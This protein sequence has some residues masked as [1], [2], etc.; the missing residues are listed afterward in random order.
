MTALAWRTARSHAASLAGAF[1]ALALGVALLSALSLTLAS[2]AGPAVGPRWFTT[3]D[4]VVAGTDS[5]TATS[6]TGDNRQTSTLATG[7]AG[8]VSAGLARRLS[9]L[10]AATVVDYAAYAYLAGAPGTTLHPW[11]A[12]ALHDFRWA[13]GGPPAG[14]GQIVLTAPTRYR[15]GDQVGVQTA[16]G[17]R[18]FEVSGVIRTSAAPALYGTDGTAAALALGRISAVALTARAGDSP[19]AL[20]ARVSAVTRGQ[21]VRVLTGA[22]RQDAQP[23][24]DAMLLEDAVSVL[25]ITAGV[26]GFVSVLVI[27][28]TFGYA[29]AARRRELGLLRAAGATPRQARRLILGEALAVSLLAA[30][31]GSAAGILLA[32]PWAGWLARSGLAPAGF[33]ARLTE[34]PAATAA[35]GTGV[36]IALAG[37]WPAA[38]RA[39]R[40]RPSEALREAELDR[41]VMTVARWIAGLAALAG[42]VPVIWASA[43]IH[44]ADASAI[45]L[46]VAALLITGCWLLGPALARSLA[47]LA[48][49][50]LAA[51]RGAAGM[52]AARGAATAIRRTVATATPVLVT[53]GLAG[54]ALAG[55]R[56]LTGTQQA[57]ARHRIT[58]P[59][60]IIPA[61]GTGLAD[62]TVAAIRA[63][64]GVTAAV[65]V[66][67][68]SVYVGN[69]QD[70]NA[71]DAQYVDGAALARVLSLPLQAGSL[72]RLTGTGTVI[73]PAGSWHLGQTA[74]LWLDDSA[75]VRLRVVGVLANQIDLAQTVLL[76]RALRDAHTAAP[77]ASRV[78]VRLA[79][80]A[81]LGRLR[82]A[83]A[84]GGGMLIPAA[85]YSS[86]AAAQQDHVTSVLLLAVLGLV[87]AYSAIAIA[88]TLAMAT[89]GRSR[90]LG[91]LRLAGATTRQVVSVVALEACLVAGFA[92][93]LAAAVTAVTVA[94]LHA[95]LSA[96][97]PA[98]RVVV[99]WPPLAGLA[100]ACLAVAVLASVIP[101]AITLR[102]PPT[103]L[104]G[105]AE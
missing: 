57:A 22:A 14:A 102:R 20:A 35:A 39:G 30:P 77:L 38:R 54:A 76:P 79:P 68:T 67:D 7:Q 101:A 86:A 49:L 51:G 26:A 99:P 66:T 18:R 105:A 23:S 93:L 42:A 95:G 13:A 46:A 91:L 33:T 65:P 56:T 31:A 71:W 8:A 72:S 6:G 12:A 59:A 5:V 21:P 87:L 64:P 16:A 78:Y 62:S 58:A 96:L 52:L 36:L 2:A 63:V 34:W 98:V 3:P 83:A 80:G 1:L 19:S 27:A 11:S 25:A 9:G 55:T 29:V 103:D 47:R 97:A 90:E 82:A 81:P 73:V 24:P 88:N 4:V 17:P 53:L 100:A 104:A 43:S 40:V 32:P 92:T 15:P 60:L 89:A 45:F 75:P 69:G 50:L 61:G 74:A 41:G 94:G 37:A 84:A 48:S 85:A 70:L 10:G 28:G 44:S